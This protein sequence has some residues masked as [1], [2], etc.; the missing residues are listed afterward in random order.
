MCIVYSVQK[1]IECIAECAELSMGNAVETVKALPH[2]EQE[3]EVSPVHTEEENFL[4][5]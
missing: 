1:Y 2:Y 3:G 4:S 5:L